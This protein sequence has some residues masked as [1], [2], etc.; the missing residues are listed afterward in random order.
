MYVPTSESQCGGVKWMQLKLVWQIQLTVMHRFWDPDDKWTGSVQYGWWVLDARQTLTI[1]ASCTVN[2]IYGEQP[3]DFLGEASMMVGRWQVRAKWGG[4]TFGVP[5]PKYVWV[6][7][8]SSAQP[9]TPPYGAESMGIEKYPLTIRLQFQS[10]K[11]IQSWCSMWLIQVFQYV[12]CIVLHWSG[13]D[14]VG[15]IQIS[16]M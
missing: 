8:V 12:L 15:Q 5:N 13:L 4:S 16:G 1:D 10:I 2:M 9:A 7:I 11:Q 6:I 14:R 3:N